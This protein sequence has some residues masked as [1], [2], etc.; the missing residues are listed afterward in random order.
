MTFCRI[1][2]F[3]TFTPSWGCRDTKTTSW[4]G[5][6]GYDI[7]TNVVFNFSSNQHPNCPPPSTPPL[8]SSLNAR[9]QLNFMPFMSLTRIPPEDLISRPPP[10]PPPH[11]YTFRL[12]PVPHVIGTDPLQS[13]SWQTDR[14]TDR[15]PFYPRP[16]INI[17]SS[18]PP[19]SHPT[20]HCDW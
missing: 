10:P 4:Y 11:P 1:S 12:L 6:R 20:S 7:G 19:P 13:N 15:C 18:P 17:I 16:V 5:D 8:P 2:W 9:N 14:Q 3:T